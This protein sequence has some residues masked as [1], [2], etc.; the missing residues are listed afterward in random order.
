MIDGCK[1]SDLLEVASHAKQSK[2]HHHNSTKDPRETG[3]Q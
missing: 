3:Y 1:N 2:F